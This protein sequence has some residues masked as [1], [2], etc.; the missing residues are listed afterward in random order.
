MSEQRQMGIASQAIPADLFITHELGAREP[1]RFDAAQE[2][3]AMQMI[4]NRMAS[5]PHDLLPYFV[6]LAMQLTEAAA[7]GLTLLDPEAPDQLLWCQ[8]RGSFR[9]F[10]NTR[11]WRDNSIC[12][13]TLEQGVVT[14]LAHPER[15]Y[16]WIAEA[17]LSMPEALMVPLH[18]AGEPI[19]T[20]WVGTEARNHFDR[21][22]AQLLA[23]LAGF[24]GIALEMTR[25]EASLRKSLEQQEIV[26]DEMSH[27]LKNV[28]AVADG[29]VRATAKRAETPD[30]MADTLTGRL[31]ALEKA[32]AL[33]QRK[34]KDIESSPAAT[35]LHRLI[36][37]I[38]QGHGFVSTIPD[39]PFS[40]TGPAVLCGEHA[41]NG[42]A[43]LVHELATNASKY[44][45]LS[46]PGGRVDVSWSVVD[47]ELTIGWAERGGPR[48]EEPPSRSGFGTSLIDRTIAAQFHGV[49]HREWRPEGLF[50]HMRLSLSRVRT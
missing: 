1:K 38:T 13:A 36:A 8:L 41:I 26:A 43:L 29:M 3:A 37:T 46:Q 16:G 45:A 6:D 22:D 9:K 32:H 7:A 14:L 2:V 23:E 40:F 20:L 49:L 21:G 31:H 15:V 27:R 10:E 50:A 44:G 12:N 47:D 39:S 11:S 17:G 30:D 19:G 48:I 5:S 4:A 25:K 42:L 18:V 33:L 35:D 28:F 34:V 24:V